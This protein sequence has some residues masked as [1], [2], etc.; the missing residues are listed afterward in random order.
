[1][2]CKVLIANRGEIACRVI[3]TARRLG[4]ATVAV[5][6]DAD[7][8]AR[9]V[10]L[11]DEAHPIGPPE[12]VQSYL[13]IDA[14]IATARASGAEA[15]HPGYGFLSENAAFAEAVAQAGLVFVGPP[16]DAIRAMG[17]K[18]AAKAIMEKAGVLVLPGYHGGRQDDRTLADA[19]AAVGYPV[20]VKAAAGGG[21][22]GMRVVELP[23]S[24]AEALASA[25]RE[26]KAAFGDDTLLIEKYLA[27]P[28][29]IEVQ[30]FA[31][32]H[33]QVVHLFERDCSL[34]RRHQ[35]IVEEAPAPGLL[36]ALRD[37]LGAA[38]VAC[39]RAIGYRNAGTVEFL[40]D[41]DGAFYFMEMNTRL[42]VEH[43]VTEMITGQDLVEWQLRVAA[44]EPLPC[45]QE[46]LSIHGHA[47]E[48][49]I[50]AED[51]ER[52][53]VPSGGRIHYLRTPA[54]ESDVRLEIGAE[55]GDDV[56]LFYD[57]MIAKVI[58]WGKDRA[59]ALQ[60][61]RDA[62]RAFRIAG[63]M[64]NVDLLAA[65][66]AHP[67]FA[68]G[69]I[70]TGFIARHRAELMPDRAGF[71]GRALALACLDV[72]L[73]RQAEAAEAARRSAD[74]HSPWHSVGGWRLNGVGRYHLHVRDRLGEVTVDVRVHD[75]MLRLESSHGV[76]TV[77][78]E[79]TAA[80]DIAATIDGAGVT[81]TVIRQGEELTIFGV[82]PVARLALIDLAQ[83]S[84]APEAWGG[85][86][87]APMPGRI[88]TVL[89][90]A[91]AQVRQG[92]TLVL[93]EAMKME[94]AIRAP[95]D[96]VVTQVYGAPGDQV[97]E[98]T[99]LVSFMESANLEE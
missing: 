61:L 63:P 52:D 99:V 28:R 25:R 22:R 1:M 26:A 10:R 84:A 8:R 79:R 2:F 30:V 41:R 85:Q 87:T 45:R 18:S 7:R 27:R 89:A 88:A 16:A 96:G 11:A 24:L 73:R 34:Q 60:R 44:G 67:A 3:R 13:N 14:L 23:E 32:G 59:R 39:A 83:R 43:P 6:S 12:P 21:G 92:D 48:A 53:F 58:A 93:L 49:R 70:D 77:A 33:G 82:G 78:G 64:T 81:A 86:L 46:D 69:D 80:G 57:P 19:A 36:P 5:Y 90:Q 29:H 72:W 75:G 47:V 95:A 50:Y 4:I 37:R 74:P 42:Q 54:E 76:T 56:G 17:S 38:A 35:K 20:L 15:V 94:H 98:G 31:D 68:A 71:A 51:P 65:I 91:G 62:L 40:L 55:E 9:H 66:V 97:E